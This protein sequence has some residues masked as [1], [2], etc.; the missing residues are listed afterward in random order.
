MQYVEMAIRPGGQIG[1]EVHP[2]TQFI[3]IE[4]GIGLAVIDGKSRVLGEGIGLIIP[5]DS[6][7][8]IINTGK[9]DMKLYTIYSPPQHLS[10]DN[11]V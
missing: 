7:H 4:S 11:I 3:R 8:N 2:V 1:E 5:P 9:V 10:T 6:K